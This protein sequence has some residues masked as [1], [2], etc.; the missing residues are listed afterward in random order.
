LYIVG[1]D[2]VDL[3][4]VPE[5]ENGSYCWRFYLDNWRSRVVVMFVACCSA[6]PNQA[7]YEQPFEVGRVYAKRDRIYL[8]R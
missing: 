1:Y 3:N 2:C 8:H 7:A 6:Q 5:V 4:G